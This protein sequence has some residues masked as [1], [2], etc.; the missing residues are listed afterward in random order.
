[1]FAP[2]TLLTPD[3]RRVMWAWL[4]AMSKLRVSENWQEVISLPRELSLPEDGV[5]RIKPLR[6]LEQLRIAPGR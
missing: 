4:F 1:M 2:E 5:L 3:G 6:E